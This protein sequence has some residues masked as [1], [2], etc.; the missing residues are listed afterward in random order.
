[1]PVPNI[2]NFAG[3]VSGDQIVLTG[4]PGKSWRTR[5]FN[6]QNRHASSSTNILIKSGA[7]TVIG[8]ILI[9]AGALLSVELASEEH[10]QMFIFEDG[11]NVIVNSDTSVPLTIFGFAGCN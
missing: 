1:M 3:T 11:D 5:Q 8:P 6:I 2:F 7:D 9:G 10:Q 4:I